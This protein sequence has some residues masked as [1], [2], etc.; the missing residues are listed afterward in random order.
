MDILEL[1]MREGKMGVDGEVDEIYLSLPHS[2]GK[3]QM[4]EED[5]VG[6]GE[7]LSGDESRLLL[8]S[9]VWTMKER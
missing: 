4:W 8:Q 3:C 9:Q 7:L 1:G 5:A 6:H 2:H